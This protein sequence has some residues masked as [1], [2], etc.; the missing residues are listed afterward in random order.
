MEDWK[1]GYKVKRGIEHAESLVIRHEISDLVNRFMDPKSEDRKAMIKRVKEL[2]KECH[3][4][5]AQG[6]SSNTSLDA[7]IKDISRRP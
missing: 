5:I 6:G 1:V 3:Q 7:Y 2:Q 4:E